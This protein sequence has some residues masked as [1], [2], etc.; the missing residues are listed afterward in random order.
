MV[1]VYKLRGLGLQTPWFGFTNS[2]VWVYKL[3]GLGL[4]TPWLNRVYL[5]TWLGL[6][7]PMDE[8]EDERLIFLIQKTGDKV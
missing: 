1:W 2:V 6:P 4:Q 5:Q 3:R 7:A 8:D